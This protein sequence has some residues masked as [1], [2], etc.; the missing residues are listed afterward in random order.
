M[1]QIYSWSEW[2]EKNKNTFVKDTVDE[3]MKLPMYPNKHNNKSFRLEESEKIENSWRNFGGYDYPL[4]KYAIVIGRW[5]K[6]S[7][8]HQKKLI[9]LNAKEGSLKQIYTF[10]QL[11]RTAY[12]RPTRFP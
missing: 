1:T 2:I 7:K 4:I 5:S 12:N 11:I 8:D 3:S 9:H 10:E 6:L